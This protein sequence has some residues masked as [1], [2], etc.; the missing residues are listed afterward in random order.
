METVEVADRFSFTALKQ[1]LGDQLSSHVSLETALLLLVNSE[2]Y[3]LP[4]LEKTC[5]EFIED[6][7]NTA[8]VL[9][10]SAFLDLPEHSLVNVLS[11]DSLVVPE[12]DIFRAL[13]RWKEG[14]ERSVEEMAEV[15]KCVR[16]SEFSSAQQ[17]FS[18][19][20]PTGLFDEKTILGAVRM[21]CS[22]TVTTMRPRGRKGVCVCVCVCVFVLY[23]QYM[24]IIKYM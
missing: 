1:A 5:W 23:L 16:L 12:I 6:E 15:L 22:P 24:T 13:L 7:S 14:N 18:E 19:V 3:H 11:R 21:I 20:E 9:N 4:N 10:C 17:V 2:K 8:K